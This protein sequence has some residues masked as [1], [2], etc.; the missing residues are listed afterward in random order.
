MAYLGAAAINNWFENLHSKLTH[1]AQL[2]RLHLELEL[3]LEGRGGEGREGGRGGEGGRR[4]GREGR[5]GGGKEG[6][7]REGETAG[8]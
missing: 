1:F 2:S 8:W 4:E 5:K 7:G 6:G 3:L